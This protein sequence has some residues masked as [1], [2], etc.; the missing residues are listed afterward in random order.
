MKAMLLLAIASLVS[1]GSPPLSAAGSQRFSAN[2]LFEA[3]SR[4]IEKLDNSSNA[5]ADSIDVPTCVMYLTGVGDTVSALPV[6][7]RKD[8]PVC[9]GPTTK[10]EDAARLVVATGVKFPVM[11]NKEVPAI[12]L[13]TAA[14]R[15]KCQDG[16]S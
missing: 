10:I 3:C 7:I 9:I 15:D 2:D 12:V 8:S 11:R 16:N 14:L 6:S 13:V 5:P 1:L 4:T